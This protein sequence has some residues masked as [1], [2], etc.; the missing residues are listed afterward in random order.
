VLVFFERVAGIQDVFVGECDG[1]DVRDA[2]VDTCHFVTY[3]VVDFNL[4]LADEVQFPLITVPDGL[5][6]LQPIDFC[7][8]NVRASL[9]LAEQE[10]RP[11]LLEV[12]AFREADAVVL[13][14]VFEAVCF[15]RDRTFGSFIA[16]FAVAGRIRLVVFLSQVE[17]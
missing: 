13:G 16:V 5:N 14:A 10:V 7:E 17:P 6:V 11:M 12:G 2:E 4:D 3:G 8:V 15:E 9:V 1:G